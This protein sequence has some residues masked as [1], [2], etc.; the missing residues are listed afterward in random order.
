MHS[1]EFIRQPEPAGNRRRPSPAGSPFY[2][3]RP[4]STWL[5]AL[6]RRTGN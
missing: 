5:A 2:L 6:N 3:G 1:S 4:R